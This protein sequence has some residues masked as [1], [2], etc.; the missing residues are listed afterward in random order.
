LS[1]AARKCHRLRVQDHKHRLERCDDSA[2]G[3]ESQPDE[4]FGKDNLWV[5]VRYYPKADIDRRRRNDLE[6]EKSE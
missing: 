2:S 5:N 6:R 3:C 1:D 4:I